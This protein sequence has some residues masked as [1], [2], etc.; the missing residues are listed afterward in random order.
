MSFK[1]PRW[2]VSSERMAPAI[3][4]STVSTT[5]SMAR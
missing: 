5:A 3:L 4:G 1:E 2:S